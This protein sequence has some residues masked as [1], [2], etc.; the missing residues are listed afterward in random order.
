MFKQIDPTIT[1]SD[2]SLSDSLPPFLAHPCPTES[3]GLGVD[4][5]VTNKLT[6]FESIRYQQVNSIRI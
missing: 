4:L 3:M 1:V 2:Y 6:R 5:F